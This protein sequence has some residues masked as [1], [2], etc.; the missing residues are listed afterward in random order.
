MNWSPTVDI[1]VPC[2]NVAHIVEQCVNSLLEQSYSENTINIYLVNDGSTDTTGKI[3]DSYSHHFQVNI[4]HHDKN[5][6]LSAA[7]NTG[8]NAGDGE[9]IFFL[10]SDM[11][12]KPDWIINH[13]NILGKDEIVGAI[14]DS[15]LPK[16]H[17]PNALDL[18]LYNER[19]GA[20]RIGEGVPIRFSYFLFNNTALKRSVFDVIELFDENITSYGGEDTELAMRLWETYPD[21]LRFSSSAGCEHHHPRELSDF[22]NSMYNYGK[23]NLP[24]LLDQFPQYTSDLG[25][26]WVNSLKGYLLFNPILRWVVSKI[27]HLSN[28]YWLIRYQVIDAVIRGVRSISP[29]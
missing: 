15:C 10:D 12:V 20:R 25:G 23:T 16:G 13:L 21:S 24:S 28:N 18:Y 8:I 22:C 2:Y 11:T 19:R 4:F 1:I 6:G 14:G 17:S 26:Q 3:L 7:R 9:I 5:R 29:R 27:H